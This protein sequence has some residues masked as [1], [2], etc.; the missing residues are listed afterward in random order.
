MIYP[1]P[2]PDQVN[3]I[4]VSEFKPD[5]TPFEI[6][7]MGAFGG[8]YFRPIWSSVCEEHFQSDYMQFQWAGELGTHLIISSKYDATVNYYKVSCG[9]SLEFWEDKGWIKSVDPRG[10]FQWYCRYHQGR[11]SSDDLRQIKRWIALS[12]RFGR[13][14]IQSSV[15]KQV[16]LHWAIKSRIIPQQI[17]LKY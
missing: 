7:S 11:R 15:V 5:Y 14:R 12:K 4:I 2:A 10:W 9:S 6:L 13:R 17:H 3:Q 8:G 1:L 16:L